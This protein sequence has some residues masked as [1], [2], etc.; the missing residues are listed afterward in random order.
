MR[1]F[2]RGLPVRKG[3]DCVQRTLLGFSPSR[4]TRFRQYFATAVPDTKILVLKEGE[5]GVRRLLQVPIYLSIYLSI[6]LYIYLYICKYMLEEEEA[7]VR[8]LLQVPIYVYK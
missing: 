4:L 2:T 1:W 5:A 3:R 7:G 8:R 6:Y